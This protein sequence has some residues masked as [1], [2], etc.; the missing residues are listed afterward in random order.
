MQHYPFQVRCTWNL[1]AAL[2]HWFWKIEN[3]EQFRDSNYWLNTAALQVSHSTSAL[4]MHNS[5]GNDPTFFKHYREVEH[6]DGS[7]ETNWTTR[8]K[9]IYSLPALRELLV[10]PTATTCS[11]CRPSKARATN[12]LDKFSQARRHEDR[13]YPGF[14]FFAEGDDVLFR[15]I[16]RGEFNISGMQNK[17]LRNCLAAK[18]SAGCRACSNACD[19]MN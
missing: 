19:C 4:A 6:R 17:S 15:A 13:S 11:S 10:A 3:K 9:T 8:Q 7:R 2:P 14:N 12:K 5:G 18:I 1:S 16:A